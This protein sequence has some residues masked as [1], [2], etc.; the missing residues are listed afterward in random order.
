MEKETS[1]PSPSTLSTLSTDKKKTKE[2]EEEERQ[3]RREKKEKFLEQEE[4]EQVEKTDFFDTFIG[5]PLQ[6]DLLL[7]ALPMCAPYQALTRVQYKIKLLPGSQK[8]GKAAKQAMGFFL[9]TNQKQE[10]Q[11]SNTKFTGI[12]S[13]NHNST[14]IHTPSV[15]SILIQRELMKCIPENEV[16]DCMIGPVKLTAPG[17]NGSNVSS[18]K[19]GGKKKK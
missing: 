9:M 12:N 10:K 19:S 13:M 3:K 8:K 17:L 4:E 16:I 6:K 7:Y 18:R 11:H 5:F 2:E 15:E 1:S 14:S